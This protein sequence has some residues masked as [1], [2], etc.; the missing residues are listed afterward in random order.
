MSEYLHLHFFEILKEVGNDDP[1]D[2]KN[3]ATR[4]LLV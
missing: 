3:K 1:H 4:F 2:Q